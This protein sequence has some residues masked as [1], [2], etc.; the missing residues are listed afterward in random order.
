M[1]T[2]RTRIGVIAPS[3]EVEHVRVVAVHAM[4]L[5]LATATAWGI[6]AATAGK[7]FVLTCEPIGVANG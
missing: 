7:A 3:G 2:Y 6:A 5:A 1:K 4:T